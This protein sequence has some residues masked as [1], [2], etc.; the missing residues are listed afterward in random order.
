MNQD[1]ANGAGT[2][3]PGPPA[4]ATAA[5]FDGNTDAV[6][7]HQLHGTCGHAAAH[8]G[9]V[10]EP[11]GAGPIRGRP[12]DGRA[13]AVLMRHAWR[14]VAVARERGPENAGSAAG[15]ALGLRML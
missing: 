9:S 1:T 10:V 11:A 14:T 13:R 7:L 5:P 12:D 2:R 6:V 15:P 4:Q 8:R 3:M